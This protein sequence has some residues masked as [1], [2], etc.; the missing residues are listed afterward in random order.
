MSKKS[1]ARIMMSLFCRSRACDFSAIDDWG[2]GSIARRL[3]RHIKV[4]GE[5]EEEE[6]EEQE[7]EEE[8]GLPDEHESALDD[9]LVVLSARA[10]LLQ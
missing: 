1:S 2:P 4:R 5:E 10:R 3:L 6:E 9:F 8:E 7:E